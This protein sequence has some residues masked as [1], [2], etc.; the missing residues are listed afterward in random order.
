VLIFIYKEQPYIKFLTTGNVIKDLSYTVAV[1]SYFD[2]TILI[3]IMLNTMI[4]ACTWH[5]E[6]PEFAV[7]FEKANLAF[8]IIYT[9]EAGIKLI[10]FGCDY[11]KDNWNR[12]DFVIVIAAWFG[13]ISGHVGLD[14]GEVT[15]LI[16]IFRISR[17]F[18]VVKKYKSLRILFYTFIEALP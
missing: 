10:A 3:C 6:P 14:V 16:R 13:F 9:I 4:L 11:F 18:K 12:F 5:G 15:N 8:N 1:N 17:I 2:S 7:E